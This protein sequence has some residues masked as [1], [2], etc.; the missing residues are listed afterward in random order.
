MATIGRSAAVAVTGPIKMQG[1]IAW[2]AWLFVH[3]IFLVGLRNKAIVF[4]NWVYSYFT[5]KRGARLIVNVPPPS[6]TA[7]ER[8]FETER[9]VPSLRDSR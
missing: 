2:L 8:A 3:L 5:Y 9:A 6:A 4:L 7:V 1:F